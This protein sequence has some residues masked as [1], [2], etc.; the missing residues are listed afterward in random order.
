MRRGRKNAGTSTSAT[1]TVATTNTRAKASARPVANAA[2]SLGSRSMVPL[3]SST[4]KTAV[5]IE[6]ATCWTM[7]ISVEPRAMVCS[8]SVARAADMIG[9]IVPPMP[10][11][12]TNRAAS[13]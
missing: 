2:G 10:R 1:I 5:P 6:A 8:R 11:P 12:I 13:R 3:V 7:F 4:E 9:I